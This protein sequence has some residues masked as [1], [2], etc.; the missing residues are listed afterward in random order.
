MTTATS[1]TLAS[2]V[3][4]SVR[5]SAKIFR[6][7][8][9]GIYAFLVSAALFFLVPLY[10]MGITSIKPM[11]EIRMGNIFAFPVAYECT[12]LLGA[13]GSL[14]GMLFLNRLPKLYNPLFQSER[15]IKATHD[16]FFLAIEATDPKFSDVETRKLLETAGSKHIEEVRD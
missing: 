1:A 16:R 8:R 7:A 15:F 4:R 13:F 9:L 6:P 11:D 3:R 2:P 10:V 14:F 12:I 5:P